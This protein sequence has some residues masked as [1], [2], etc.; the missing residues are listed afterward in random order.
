[1]EKIKNY[2]AGQLITIPNVGV[3]RV[4]RSAD[5]PECACLDCPFNNTDELTEKIVCKKYCYDST[6]SEDCYLKPVIV[7]KEKNLID[8]VR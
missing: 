3:V 5:Y 7:W 4:T 2:K 6:L 1:M 8:Q